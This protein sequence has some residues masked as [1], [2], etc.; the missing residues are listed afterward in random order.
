MAK[1]D[2]PYYVV[3]KGK[4][5]YWQPTKTMREAGFS[6]IRC[7]LDGPDAWK[8]AATW[9]ERWQR[10]RQGRA[11]DETAKWPPRSVGEGF[12]RFRKTDEWLIN[13]RPRT[14]EEWERA[15]ARISPIF[16]D[17]PPT[18]PE[19][20]LESLS[21]FRTIIANTVSLREA[22]RTIKIWRALWNVLI[23]LGY[24]GGKEDPSLG[25]TNSAPPPRS[26]AWTEGEAVRLAKRA[27]REGYHGLAVAIAFA[28]DTQFSPVDLRSLTV[29]MIA[30]EDSNRHFPIS[31]T[32]TGRA[33]IGT[34]GRRA[35]ALLDAYLEKHP[36]EVGA[37]LRNRSGAPYSRFTMPDD[38]AAVRDLVFPADKRT[39]ADMRRSGA[40]E[41]QAGG[42]A[43]AITSAKMANSIGSANAIHRTY[44]PV[45]L[46][47]VRQADEARRVGRRRIRETSKK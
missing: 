15:W 19:I 1:V 22:W 2:I 18:S 32:K 10:H 41:L 27:W 23:A 5:G 11:Q 17:L 4:Y 9:N 8:I 13:K 7:G 28:W 38:F 47:T 45:D 46:T 16:G 34:L 40:I 14:R 29:A 3:K 20:N 6:A 43:P 26:A 42:A 12:E 30:G 33:G 21:Q 37:I 25:I 24:C 44:Q 31:R 36:C 39:L 35:L